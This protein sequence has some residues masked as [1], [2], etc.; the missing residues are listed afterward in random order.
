MLSLRCLVINIF[1]HIM[2]KYCD[3]HNSHNCELINPVALKCYN[4]RILHNVTNK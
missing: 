3:G 4:D 1:G 2:S